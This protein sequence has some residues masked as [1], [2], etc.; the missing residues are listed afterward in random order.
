MTDNQRRAINY[1]KVIEA[2]AVNF[3]NGWI[4]LSEVRDNPE[5]ADSLVS[6]LTKHMICY[7]GSPTL[8]WPDLI[9]A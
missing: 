2:N 5:Q 8:P 9:P 3:G 6:Q 7:S 4:W 1:F